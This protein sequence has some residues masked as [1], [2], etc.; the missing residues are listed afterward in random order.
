MAN[1]SC[2]QL[3]N[4]NSKVVRCRD[5]IDEETRNVY[6]NE[7]ADDLVEEVRS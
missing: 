2:Q 3:E 7:I 6:A 1:R 5:S 4:I